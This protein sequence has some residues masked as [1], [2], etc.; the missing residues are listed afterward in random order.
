[1]PEI[2][3]DERPNSGPILGHHRTYP[4]NDPH[5]SHGCIKS[6]DR[7]HRDLR[8]SG[9]LPLIQH[10]FWYERGKETDEEQRGCNQQFEDAKGNEPW[11]AV[12]E[13]REWWR[14]VRRLVNGFHNPANT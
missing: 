8:R 10:F 2:T 4:E 11:S 9:L 1:Q 6:H 3:G 13:R 5:R 14:R 7:D 12:D